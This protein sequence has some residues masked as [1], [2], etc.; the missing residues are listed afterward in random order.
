MMLFVYLILECIA[1]YVMVLLKE[2]I[3]NI[4]GKDE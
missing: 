4:E 3:E 2:W 1:L